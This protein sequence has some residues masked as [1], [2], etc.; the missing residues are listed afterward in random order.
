MKNI[1]LAE[2]RRH[3][4]M[5]LLNE[6]G[7]AR[8]KE[9]SLLFE[10]SEPTIR[11]DLATLEEQGLIMRRHGGAFL[12]TIPKQVSHLLVQNSTNIE[13]KQKI[14]KKALE[15]IS[16][17]DSIILDS[18]ST[19][20][21]LAKI[22]PSTFE[23]VQIVT[24]ALNIA[25]L[26]GQHPEFDIYLIG[27]AF[28]A[29][30]LSTT[31]DKALEFFDSITTR[32]VFLATGGVSKNGELTY[33]SIADIPL[34]KVMIE[35]AERVVLLA[36]SSKFYKSSFAVLEQIDQVVDYLITDEEL[37]PETK[38]ELETHKTRVIIA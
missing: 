2:D 35:S 26:L 18:G 34:K 16:N 15:F 37:A 4:I 32:T 30:T 25:L 6:D 36:D 28:K 5:E 8:V 20:T 1:K 11:T 13:K 21:E 3:K 23:F 19:I 24:N 29:P 12:K 38:E 10:V 14:A 22:L 27:G 33:P 7:S 17:E 9:L 31:G